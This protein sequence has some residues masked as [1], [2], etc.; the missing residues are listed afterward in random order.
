LRAVVAQLLVVVRDNVS[1][2]ETLFSESQQTIFIR[3]KMLAKGVRLRRVN[4]CCVFEIAA[5]FPLVSLLG[6]M[7]TTG[8]S[9]LSW[10]IN[11]ALV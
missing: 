3:A 9:F 1:V 6:H 7:R 2:C 10:R 4:L 11:C 8:N 5:F